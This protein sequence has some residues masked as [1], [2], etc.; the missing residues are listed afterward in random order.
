MNDEP[1]DSG[2]ISKLRE[3]RDNLQQNLTALAKVLG[4]YSDVI[5][6]HSSVRSLGEI[7]NKV[8]EDTKEMMEDN[9]L[10]RLGVVGQVKAGKSSLLNSLLFKGEEVLPKAATPMTA[11]LTH[12]VK[13]DRDEIEIEYYIHEDWEEI[14][15]HAREFQRAKKEGD[16]RIPQFV[17]ASHDLVAMAKGRGLRVKDHLGKTQTLA[18][19]T[20]KLNEEL[21]R[22]VGSE[23]ELTPLVKSVTIH[24]SEGFPDL[25][26]VD[27][28]GINDPIR[29]RSRQANR[30]LSRCDAVL[31]LSY[32]GQFMDNVDVDFFVR[33]IPQEGIRHRVMIG[34]KFDSSLI[35]VS[36][37]H[38]GNLDQAQ[39]DTQR[40]LEEHGREAIARLDEEQESKDLPQSTIVFVSAMCAIL[41]GKPTSRWT[42][43]EQH[44]FARLQRAYPDWLDQ[45]EDGQAISEAT[46]ENLIWLGNREAI[47]E[48]LRNVRR[49]KDEIISQKMESFLQE[50]CS[51][52]LEELDELV[53]S[54]E[55]RRTAIRNG[56]IDEI[57]AQRKAVGQ[58]EEVLSYKVVDVWGELIDARADERLSQFREKLR[59]EGKKAKE[60]VERP[61]GYKERYKKPAKWKKVGREIANIFVDLDEEKNTTYKVPII[62]KH[63][64]EFAVEEF[65]NWLRD[66]TAEKI[67]EMFN[68]EFTRLATKTVRAIV[69]EEFSN[70]LAGKMDLSAVRRSLGEAVDKIVE[71]ARKRLGEYELFAGKDKAQEFASDW[72]GG[73]FGSA[74]KD[75]KE[76]VKD[77]VQAG[78]VWLDFFK[79]QIDEVANKAKTDLRPATVRSLQEYQEQLIRDIKDREFILQRCDRTL[80][81]LKE[82]R[83]CLEAGKR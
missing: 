3:N 57:E 62:D 69:A 35:D 25:D 12:I 66:Q 80:K 79:D 46:K 77:I 60:K 29:S 61:V 30:M 31:L 73:Q 11:S 68:R 9:R 8:A 47:D 44:V 81:E 59:E 48:H 33:R 21:R 42:V 26:I 54:V 19:P 14:K 71:Q 22:L 18:V 32:A 45:P 67:E 28:P 16:E 70:D 34:S 51:Q 6:G 65:K 63:G 15:K 75:P 72:L 41:A 17:E 36:R 64:Q 74:M 82:Y 39:E 23:G 43:E 55:E 58:L 53:G 52:T 1:I 56:D 7:T 49:D 5:D 76:L 38:R 83:Q 20:P 40:R 24:S 37:D 4:E 2:P 50:K 78:I 13:S 27:T 10:L